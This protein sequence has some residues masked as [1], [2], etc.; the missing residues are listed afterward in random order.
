MDN[1]FVSKINLSKS[2]VYNLSWIRRY[3]SNSLNALSTAI[4]CDIFPASFKTSKSSASKYLL[5]F[6]NL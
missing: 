3:F 6:L 5:F 4:S 1:Y 2:D